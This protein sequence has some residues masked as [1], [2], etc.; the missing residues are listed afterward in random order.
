MG[1]ILLNLALKLLTG[2]AMESLIAIGINKL[3]NHQE[4]GIGKELSKTMIKKHFCILLLII[5][6]SG[7]INYGS[8]RIDQTKSGALERAR[9]ST[10]R[11]AY[12]RMPW[13]PLSRR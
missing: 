10:S 12:G 9:P 7:I 6:F 1:T 11:R 2:K 13:R 4:D 5:C 8:V 3:L